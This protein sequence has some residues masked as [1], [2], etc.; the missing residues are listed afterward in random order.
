[1][2]TDPP[3]MPETTP[4][5]DPTVAIVVLLLLQVPPAEA[6]VRLVV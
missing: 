3:V 2:T 1:M 4:V 5:F 6:F